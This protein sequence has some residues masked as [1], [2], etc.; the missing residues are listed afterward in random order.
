[1]YEVALKIHTLQPT[2]YHMCTM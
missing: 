2:N 1:L